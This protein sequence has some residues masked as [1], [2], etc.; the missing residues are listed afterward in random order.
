VVVTTL[1]QQW[2]R[3]P[4]PGDHV[5]QD[6][7]DALDRLVLATQ[8]RYPV[9]GELARSA[10]FRWFDQPVVES[11]RA[12]ALAGARE[13]VEYLA[14]FPDAADHAARLQALAANPQAV[15][16]YH[17]GKA[18][19]IRP[20]SQ[21]RQTRKWLPE[22]TAEPQNLAITRKAFLLK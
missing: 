20:P 4:P 7:H 6:T 19:A 12:E 13:E 18:A 5:G 2:L 14:A 9:V 11:A 8:L 21:F 10:R 22:V 15:A 1:L 17:A 3:D 16:D